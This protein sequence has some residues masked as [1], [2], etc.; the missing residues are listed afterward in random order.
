MT[1]QPARRLEVRF[2]EGFK[3]GNYETLRTGNGPVAVYRYITNSTALHDLWLT[4]K[5]KLCRNCEDPK[6]VVVLIKQKKIRKKI[7]WVLAI[8]KVS[9]QGSSAS[10]AN[11]LKSQH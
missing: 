8:P 5:C 9:S 4:S 6:L 1:L 2:W 7:V 10:P 3:N 11:H